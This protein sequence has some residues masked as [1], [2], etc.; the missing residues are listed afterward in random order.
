MMSEWL[1]QLHSPPSLDPIAV[2]AILQ[3]L[4]PVLPLCY[5]LSLGTVAAKV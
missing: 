5:P 4:A 3:A 2:F 1:V